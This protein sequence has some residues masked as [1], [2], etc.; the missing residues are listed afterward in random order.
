M[1]PY[2]EQR[3]RQHARRRHAEAEQQGGEERGERRGDQRSERRVAQEPGDDQPGGDGAQPDAPVERKQHAGRRGHT[4]AAGEAVEQREQVAEKHGEAGERHGADV[5]A[6][7]ADEP[8]REPALARV[9]GERKGGGELL[10]AA[11][12]I[13]RSRITRAIAARI[14]QPREPAHH[15]GE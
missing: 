10:A 6:V 12:D 15:D 11:Q 13:G 5:E 9:S 3:D 7:G 4:L 2:E 1:P 14:G 8:H